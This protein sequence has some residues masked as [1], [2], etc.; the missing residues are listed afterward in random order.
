[1]EL[2][3]EDTIKPLD[4]IFDRESEVALMRDLINTSAC[5]SV[6]GLR[7]VGKTTLIRSVA[8]SIRDVLPVYHNLWGFGGTVEDLLSEL[9]DKIL[10]TLKKMVGFKGKLSEFVRSLELS[11][12]FLRYKPKKDE[13]PRLLD[14]VIERAV[15]YG[16]KVGILLDEFQSFYDPRLL[17][18][19]S[20]LRDIFGTKIFITFSGSVASLKRF[21]EAD[22]EAPFYGRLDEKILIEPFN[23]EQA[24]M[25]LR[26]GFEEKGVEISNEVIE[27]AISNLGGFPGWLVKFGK[28]MCREKKYD[29]TT[30][31][32]VLRELF[33]EAKKT[34]YSEIAR[35]LLDRKAPHKY[36]KILNY[37]SIRGMAGP[38]DIV[39]AGIVR[40]KSLASEYLNFLTQYG[41]LKK[42]DRKYI[43]PDPLVLRTANQ[44]ELIREVKKRIK[45]MH[46]RKRQ[47]TIP[48]HN[49]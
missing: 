48:K 10:A 2:F 14:S 15:D 20:A 35:V 39:N 24:K 4:K 21:I 37:I 41:L 46:T 44:P 36:L 47:Q 38:T 5:F 45:K 34:I 3:S 7:R 26:K 28:K 19:L 16:Y 25:F 22:E 11:V 6:S 18:R 33:N 42:I 12:L 9:T 1:M 23:I 17:M 49:N 43:I 32:T 13:L 8:A 29:I 30:A 31:N 40:Q 27:L